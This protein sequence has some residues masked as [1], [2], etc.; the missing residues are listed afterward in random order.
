MTLSRSDSRAYRF[1]AYGDFA[2]LHQAGEAVETPGPGQVL[3]DVAAVA[4]NYRDIAIALGRHPSPHP[5]G[6]VP[7]SDAAGTVLEVGDDVVDLGV[8]D[9]VASAFHPTWFGGPQPRTLALDQW[10]RGRDGWLMER[11]VVER[12]ALV[13]LQAD[14]DLLAAATVPCSAT[15]A[16]TCLR[17]GSKPIGAA[18]TVL[19]LGTGSVSLFTV[20]L[21]KVLGASVISTTSTPEKAQLLRSLGADHVIN[22]RTEP[23]WGDRARELAAGR[24]VDIVVE[25]GGPGT[26][27]QSLRAVAEDAELAVVGFLDTSKSSIDFADFFR[28]GAHLRQIRVGDRAALTEVFEVVTRHA[29]APVID[30]IHPFDEAVGA[31]KHL[32]AGNAVGK[33]LIQM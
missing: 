6:L 28:S 20:Q 23:R 25:V 12:T 13:K 22:Y 1:S 33:V 30:S 4:L 3:V 8:G 14:Q 29:I 15:T 19:T 26:I 24:G 2:H 31:F 17:G 9:K 16:W 18:Q 21:A 27:G 5:A 7:V 11:K 32:A 10:G